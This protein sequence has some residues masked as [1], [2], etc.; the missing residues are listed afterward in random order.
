MTRQLSS[1]QGHLGQTVQQERDLPLPFLSAQWVTGE[2]RRRWLC[3]AFPVRT[4][5]QFYCSCVSATVNT[6]QLGSNMAEGPLVEWVIWLNSV[7]FLTYDL[8]STENSQEESSLE[9]Y[10]QLRDKECSIALG[11]EPGK[12]FLSIP[13]PSLI[14]AGSIQPLQAIQ[15]VWI[16]LSRAQS[17]RTEAASFPKI[18]GCIP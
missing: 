13:S 9:T 8:T 2:A 5:F 10:I 11:P 16:G 6:G 14:N 4:C 3:I 7:S 17:P 18:D 15:M 12:L 1:G